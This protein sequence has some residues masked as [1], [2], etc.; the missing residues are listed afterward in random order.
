MADFRID[1]TMRDGVPDG[2]PDV[3]CGTCAHFRPRDVFRCGRRSVMYGGCE[4][5]LGHWDGRPESL[6]V[7]ET[8]RCE[9]WEEYDG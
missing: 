8:D 2:G 7:V 6:S 5:M 3:R 4:A 1:Q 9:L